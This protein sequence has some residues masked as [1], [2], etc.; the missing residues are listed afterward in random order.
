MNNENSDIYLKKDFFLCW[1]D[2]EH[3]KENLNL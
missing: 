2:V 1:K 3:Y